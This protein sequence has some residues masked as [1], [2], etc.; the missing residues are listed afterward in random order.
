MQSHKRGGEA[1]PFTEMGLEVNMRSNYISVRFN[2][3][4]ARGERGRDGEEDG[5]DRQKHIELDVTAYKLN[6]WNKDTMRE[7]RGR[8]GRGRN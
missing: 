1:S 6:I 3:E 2:Y 8:V 7:R 5:K 4:A